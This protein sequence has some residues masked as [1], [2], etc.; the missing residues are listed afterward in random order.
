[1]RLKSTVN[2]IDVLTIDEML[3]SEGEVFVSMSGEAN[4]YNDMYINK[5]GA[6]LIIEHLQKVFNLTE[7]K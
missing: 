3:D 6:E 7:V 2:H 4:F 1:M 5:V